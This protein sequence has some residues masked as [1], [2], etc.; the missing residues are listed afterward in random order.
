MNSQGY[1][2]TVFT[3][4]FNRA[5]KII[6]VYECLL[7]QTFKDFEW[8]IV[9][10]GSTDNTNILIRKIKEENKIAIRYFFQNNGGKHRAF[11]KAISEAKGEWLIC[12]DS[13]DKYMPD[14]LAKLNNY[15]KDINSYDIAGISCLSIDQNGKIIGDK[16]PAN[17]FVTNH[18][19]LY[20]RKKI[21][22]DKGLI[23]KTEILKN[24]QFPEIKGE[25]FL[26]EAVVLNRISREYNI[27]CINEPLEIK[28]YLNDG[29]S[30]RIRYLRIRNPKGFAL[31][32][33][34]KNNFNLKLKDRIINTSLYVKYSL[35]A[36]GKYR[37][38]YSNSIYKK[39]FVFYFI[40]GNLLYLRSVILNFINEKKKNINN[41]R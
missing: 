16:F 30:N 1:K 25:N 21:R 22:G 9:D 10:D 36:K 8:L 33:N 11:N 6:N 15:S 23:Y 20:Y 24:F 12:L 18:F 32:H 40:L 13:D 4:T 41:N 7:A 26:T 38:I 3:P 2:F 37:S 34:E 14:A 27:M 39:G 29:L 35:F 19:D 5:H 28:E 31:F 17:K